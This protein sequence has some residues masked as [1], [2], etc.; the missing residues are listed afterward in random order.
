MIVIL[1][2]GGAFGSTLE[3]SLR[4]FSNEF[5]K[6]HAEVMPDGSMHSF[7]KGWHPISIDQYLMNPNPTAEIITPTYTGMDYI[8][9]FETIMKLKPLIAP[10]E[11]VVVVAFSTLGMAERN[12]LFA[13][14]KTPTF[15]SRVLHNK[16]I[17]WNPEYVSISD[18]K[19]YEIREGLSF[20]IDY[21]TNHAEVIENPVD[22]WLYITPDDVLF[23]FKTTVLKMIDHCGLTANLAGLDDF[24]KSWIEKQQYILDEFNTVNSIVT[25]IKSGEYYSWIPISIVGE[26]IVQSRLRQMGIEIACYNLNVFP[27]D[28][29]N[30]RKL[31]K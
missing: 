10:T 28:T 2:P 18:M 13:Y 7:R 4:Q 25:S 27:T 22:E 3:Y 24:Y 12:Q 14:Y 19:P 5:T 31:L 6:V 9:P 29:S 20:H 30:L 11:K 16:H 26:A 15:I 1:F 17:D 21:Q 8:S 23:D